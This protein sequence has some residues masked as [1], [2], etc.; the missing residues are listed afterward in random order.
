MGVDNVHG[1]SHYN[2]ILVLGEQELSLCP[3][4]DLS[5]EMRWDRV[6]VALFSPE[7]KT[8]IS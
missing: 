5:R 7:V 6:E 4:S 1:I 8:P 3:V 2:S